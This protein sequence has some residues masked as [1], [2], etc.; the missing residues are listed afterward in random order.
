MFVFII[1]VILLILVF[2]W[3][4]WFL[5]KRNNSELQLFADQTGKLK[6]NIFEDKIKSL[7][8]MKLTG[9][10]LESFGKGK[11]DYSKL[12]NETVPKLLAQIS[13]A[14]NR[15]SNFN[16]FGAASDLK[17]I[18][19]Q[20]QDVENEFNDIDAAFSKIVE[21]NKQ[22]ASTSEVLHGDYEK[23]RKEILTKSF[24]YGPATD[25]LESELNEIA[26]FLDEEKKL[27]TQGDHLEARQYLDDAK[28]KLSM[29]KDQVQLIV[30]LFKNLDKVFPGQ[31]EEI[32]SVYQK[33]VQQQY[34]FSINVDEEIESVNKNIAKSNEAL[35]EL[36]F[37]VVDQLNEK[38]NT[39]INNLYDVLS[40][41]INAKRQVLKQQ[42][43]V[44]DYLNHAKF[45]HNRLDEYIQTLEEN[46][47]LNEQD[48]ADFKEHGQTLSRIVT[49][50]DQDVQSIADKSMV[51]SKAES[52]FK[53]IVADLDKIESREKTIND[54]L[55]Q[56][57]S[58]EEISKKSV[59]KY[60]HRIQLQKKSLEQLNL[61]GLP[62]DYLE[63]FFMVSD[64]IKK[65]YDA[66]N[67]ERINMEEISKQV[68]VTQEDLDN[69]VEKTRGLREN[70]VLDEKLLQY[71][72]RYAEQADFKEQLDTARKLFDEEFEYEQALDVISKA[73]E[74][75]EPGAVDRI[76]DTISA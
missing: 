50:Y 59:D 19:V 27:T 45:Q 66:L 71:A 53:E 76:R 4:M 62:E 52:D 55:N 36:N 64:E 23:L 56:M 48:M 24:N 21:S 20:S 40:L 35:G 58:S 54:N 75:K 3:Y 32:Q 12:Q 17:K 38:I 47:I 34:R 43:P 44:L 25:K 10:S 69:L 9:A 60:A 63:Y 8:E 41:E 46:Y 7:E 29:V 57:L 2:L 1:V 68:I 6:E 70:V 18:K 28:V 42:K 14:I 65:L 73:L 30:P 11:Q 15:N 39:D 49:E 16:V 37:D 74:S 5:Q 51:F 31:I 22:N 13:N 26:G 61:R 33:L 72:N 67:S